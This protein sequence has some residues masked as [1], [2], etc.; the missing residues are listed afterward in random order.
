MRTGGPL[1]DSEDMDLPVWAG[2]IP[3]TTV[4]G[5]PVTVDDL[6]GDA[7]VPPYAAVYARP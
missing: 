4:A 3:L 2:V 6:R 7:P 5:A 1:D